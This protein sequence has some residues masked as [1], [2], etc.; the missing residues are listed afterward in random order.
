MSATRPATRPESARPGAGESGR[1]GLWTPSSPAPHLF[2]KRMARATAALRAAGWE[3]VTA[4]HTLGSH[5]MGAAEP[6]EVAEDLH[7]LLRDTSV[8]A[9]MATTGGYTAMEVLPW[10]DYGLVRRRN[11]PVI[12]YSDVSCVLWAMAAQGVR[13][14]IHGPMA[15]S[16]FGHFGGPF[17]YALDSLRGALRGHGTTVLRPPS[18]YTDDDPWWDRDDE[19]PLTMRTATPWR[20]L[21]HGVAQGRLLAGCLFSVTSLFGTRYWPDVSGRVLFLED[22]GT[23]PDQLVPLLAQWRL[24][25]QLESVAGVVF[26]RRARP[27]RAAS[28]WADFDDT[29]LRA[30]DGIDVPIVTDVDFGHTEPM[31]SLPLGA[32]VRLDTDPLAITLKERDGA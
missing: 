22:F 5:R 31:L 11:V 14:L 19:R 3:P 1:I 9:V 2:P 21:R 32:E 4:P 24:S 8:G 6:A 20:V 27:G 28:G 12:G 17:P 10:I 26:A 18:E 30:F 16:E 23:G 15:V 7:R 13:S 29:V 25:G